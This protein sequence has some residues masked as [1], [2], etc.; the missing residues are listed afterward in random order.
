M[1]SRYA[2]SLH[3]RAAW[4]VLEVEDSDRRELLTLFE[5]LASA[6]SRPATE[7]VIDETGRPNAVTY[8][9]HFRVIYWADHA[10]KEIRILDVRRY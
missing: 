3:E 8:T 10:V 4:A 5:T 7:R 2:Y 9:A 6:P 1:I